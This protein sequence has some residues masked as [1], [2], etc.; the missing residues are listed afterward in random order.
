LL[1]KQ[2]TVTALGMAAETIERDVRRF[3]YAKEV[4][5]NDLLWLIL[6]LPVKDSLEKHLKL[7]IAETIVMGFGNSGIHL[8]TN[9]AGYVSW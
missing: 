5:P 6:G 7:N 4:A 9:E 8:K 2:A 1:H 3:L